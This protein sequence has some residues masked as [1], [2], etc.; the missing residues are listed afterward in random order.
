MKSFFQLFE[1]LELSEKT[2]LL[3]ENSDQFMNLTKNRA[4][5]HCY[6]PA[7]KIAERVLKREKE[8]GNL[9]PQ[10]KVCSKE[11]LIEVVEN[12][13]KIKNDFI[14]TMKNYVPILEIDTSND[15][16]EN[17]KRIDQFIIKHQHNER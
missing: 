1:N 7:E 15:I 8:Q 17:V 5:I 10:Y 2:Q 9:L 16:N 12:S 3:E 13:L 11:V 14:S 4:I 6:A